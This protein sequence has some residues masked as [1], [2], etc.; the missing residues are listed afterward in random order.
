MAGDGKFE[1]FLTILKK[2]HVARVQ[3]LIGNVH[4]QSK[5]WIFLGYGHLYVALTFENFSSS[6]DCPWKETR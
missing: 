5:K 4:F 3:M 2:T 1:S 6:R